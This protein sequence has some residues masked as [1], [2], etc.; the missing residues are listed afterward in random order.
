MLEHEWRVISAKNRAAKA[1]SSNVELTM[2]LE[3]TR[4]TQQRLEQIH[5]G[6]SFTTML[7]YHLMLPEIFSLRLTAFHTQIL[8]RDVFKSL[9]DQ[10]E[11]DGVLLILFSSAGDCNDASGARP[12]EHFA[13]VAALLQLL[14]CSCSSVMRHLCS[15][16][17]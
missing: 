11:G 16:Y 6:L 9:P 4:D 12:Q 5:H 13:R 8:P 3:N 17:A 2:I 10:I 15:T 1:I 7:S 14:L